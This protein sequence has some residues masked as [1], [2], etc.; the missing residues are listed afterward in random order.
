LVVLLKLGQTLAFLQAAAAAAG[1]Q[2]FVNSDVDMQL[3]LHVC[4]QTRIL[5]CGAMLQVTSSTIPRQTAMPFEEAARVDSSRRTSTHLQH[6]LLMA[7][8]PSGQ[9]LCFSV[10]GST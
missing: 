9:Q 8:K 6:A 1:V 4:V 10:A 3:S 7:L 2:K 5:H